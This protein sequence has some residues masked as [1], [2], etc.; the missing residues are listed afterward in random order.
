MIKVKENV[1]NDWNILSMMASKG[2]V[3]QIFFTIF[4]LLEKEKHPNLLIPMLIN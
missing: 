2:G 1:R 4:V 3:I